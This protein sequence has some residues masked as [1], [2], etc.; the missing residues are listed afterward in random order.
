MP[1]LKDAVAEGLRLRADLEQDQEHRAR[2]SLAA[3]PARLPYGAGA[4]D[5]GGFAGT[6]ALP[7]NQGAVNLNP[8][9]SSPCRRRPV[10]SPANPVPPSCKWTLARACRTSGYRLNKGRSSCPTTGL[11]TCSWTRGGPRHD[12]ASELSTGSRGS[13]QDQSQQEE[14]KQGEGEGRVRAGRSVTPVKASTT[15]R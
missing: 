13:Q 11:S 8:E 14:A 6:P 3:P 7:S 1:L 15:L 2:G 4:G 12:R 9:P 10:P 5:Q